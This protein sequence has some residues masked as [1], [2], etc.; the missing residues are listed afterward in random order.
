MKA[1][2]NPGR[3]GNDAQKVPC[4]DD[5]MML[6]ITKVTPPPSPDITPRPFKYPTSINKVLE[7]YARRIREISLL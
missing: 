4:F 6:Q 5:V 3:T 2:S 7:L 1:Q